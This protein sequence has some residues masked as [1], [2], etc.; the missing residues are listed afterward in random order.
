MLYRFGYESKVSKIV[1][2]FSRSIPEIGYIARTSTNGSEATMVNTFID[3]VMRKYSCLKKKHVA[4]FLEPQVDTGYPDIVIVEYWGQ[5]RDKANNSRIKLST[6][7]LRILFHV[8]QQ[9]NVSVEGLRDLLGFTDIEIRKSL[10]RLADSQLI[11]L[12]KSKHHAR[13]RSLNAFNRVK[14]IIAIE[15][16]IDKWGEAI[17]QAEKNAWFSTDS[18]VLLNKEK[19]SESIIQKCKA[20]G[21]GIILVNGQI[22]VALKGE[23][24]NHPISYTSL[25]FNEWIY[26]ITNLEESP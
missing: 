7:D 15:A 12:S 22:K 14:R 10:L 5:P 9:K 19:C 4:V 2:I 23:H 26:R 13:N 1:Q 20:K 24:R 21:L 11:H 17:Q 6:I 16:K 8:N 25:L 18:F 3:H